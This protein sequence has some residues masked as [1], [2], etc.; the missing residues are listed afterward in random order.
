MIDKK[1]EN[2]LVKTENQITKIVLNRPEKFNAIS[3]E[4]INDL[5]DAMPLIGSDE[6]TR[7]VVIT[8][9]G[10]A[11]CA[12]GDIQEDLVPVSKMS[13]KEWRA[14]IKSFCDVIR[15]LNRLPKPVIAAINGVTVGG[16]CDIAMSCDIRIASDK[17]RFGYGYIQMAIISDMGGHF[18]LPRLIGPGRAKLFAFTGELIDAGEAER[19]GLVDRLAPDDKFNDAVDALATKIATGPTAAIVLIKEAMRR[20]ATMDLDTSLDYALNLQS[21]ILDSEDLKEGC[22]AFLEKRKPNFKGK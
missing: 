1:Y 12:G 5:T 13:P 14:Y 18:M 11:F 6:D 7:A 21:S 15:T 8:G 17:A 3:P 9:T 19:I 16:G 22:S 2:I 20:S 4:L 10:K